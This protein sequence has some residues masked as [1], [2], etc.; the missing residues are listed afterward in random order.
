MPPVTQDNQS[1]G[2]VYWRSLD[3]LSQS[4]EFRKWADEEFGGY[5]PDEMVAAP[6]RRAFMK[7][8]GASMALAGAGMTGCRRWPEQKVAPYVERP[9]G[10]V[11]GLPE[12][13][14]TSY[15]FA[16]IAQPLLVSS[17]DGRPI[18]VE[19]N[20]QH[21][22]S[23]GPSTTY[24][25]ASVLDMYDP[26][27]SRNPRMGEDQKTWKEAEA[28][29]R[30]LVRVA[31]NGAGIAVL[32]E[33]TGSP[34][35]NSLRKRLGNGVKWYEYEAINADHERAGTK[36]AFGEA[37]RPQL[38]LDAAD[39]IVC[40]D[41]DPLG[42]HPDAL[43]NARGWAKGR[44]TVDGKD[45][46]ISRMYVVEPAYTV[47]GTVADDRVAVKAGEIVT[48]AQAI[49]AGAGV[50]GVTAGGKL[51]GAAQATVDAI[52]ADLKANAGK[53]VVIVG[54]NQPA[55]VHA[56]VALINAKSG[57]VG[58]TVSYTAVSSQPSGPDQ[59]RKLHGELMGGKVKALF[60]VGGNPVY[61]GPSDINLAEAIAD[62]G[63][64]AHL[65]V[66]DNETSQAC[67][68]H[69]ARS[70][71]LEAWGDAASYDGAIGVVQPLIQ[72]LFDT[73]SSV[74]LLGM[75]AGS[76]AD[77]YELVR[78]TWKPVLTGEGG[79]ER[80]WRKVLHDGLLEGS[81]AA[82]VS[83]TASAA[84]G[85]AVSAA[86]PQAA[87]D[88]EIVFTPS[89]TAYDGRLANNGWLQETPEPIS[90]LV[91]DNAA[92]ISP[93]TAKDNS[94]R[95]GD[96]LTIAVGDVSI[97][98][99][100][101]ILPG[102]ANGSIRL[103]LGYGRSA[104]G[105]VGNGVGFNAYTLRSSKTMGFAS[106]TVEKAGGKFQLVTTQDHHAIDIVG[107]EQRHKRVINQL[108]R[109]ATVDQYEKYPHFVEQNGVPVPTGSNG[110]TPLQIFEEPDYQMGHGEAGEHQWAMAIDLN[111]CIGCNACMVAC[112]AENNIPIVGKRE[113]GRGREMHWIRVDRYFVSKVD[114]EG[115]IDP[116]ET[117]AAV[118][119]PLTCQ[120]CENAPCEQV[121][122][123][124]ATV[125]DTEGLNVMIY[126]RCIGTRYCSNNCPY[127]VRRYNWFD[128][129][130][131]PVRS[132]DEGAMGDAGGTFIGIPDQQQ[133]QTGQIDPK[134]GRA[135]PEVGHVDPI[136][137]LGFNPEVTV[138]MRGVMEKCSFCVQ[139]IKAVTIPLRN[140]AVKAAAT[141]DDFEYELPDGAITPACG[142]T[143][144]TNAIKFGDLKDP[145]S[146]VAKIY[147]NHEGAKAHPRAYE[148]L[149]ELNPR[150]RNRY[151]GPV[152]NPAVGGFTR[153]YEAEQKAQKE[154]V[155]ENHG[156]DDHGHDDKNH[157]HDDKNKAAH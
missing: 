143:C 64:S 8:M 155:E 133:L 15:E 51:S 131:K 114:G 58:K 102:Q 65:S 40:L 113:C 135:N 157:D 63:F 152:R 119:Q 55:E 82:T 101:F 39:I 71:Y 129:N 150:A 17:Y 132:G 94:I 96:R 153:D 11:P 118:H 100:A 144:P 72:P 69:L 43:R 99:P 146:D 77:G 91:W 21:P 80:Q 66:Y 73:K 110:H 41:A 26:H 44:S 76:D 29:I 57:A 16:G 54:P 19:G 136:R 128:W 61:D 70:H 140:K 42:T 4:P 34:T 90:K 156:H 138:R 145:G 3:E 35:S 116:N 60:I 148:I 124:A 93:R 137:R 75:L 139:R 117:V 123:V 95:H 18:K 24:A 31:P 12:T 27:R 111:A 147:G 142:Q 48:V 20:P 112:Q 105:Y 2:M 125:H 50:D 78:Q 134:T 74:E 6:S 97:V 84:A 151:L 115:N 86:K 108:V 38:K 33:A 32:S 107:L 83:V 103:D 89:A 1:T 109:G 46:K 30:E 104:A 92:Y 85:S 10:R 62:I 154:W 53:A 121:C 37:V 59:L 45:H 126:N 122:P 22:A 5:N 88:F 52:V 68:W 141:G 14:A 127:K 130:F 120:Q 28:A 49:A 9:A 56:A 149:R 13:F 98:A 67:S 36:L 106:A 23:G 81:G 87:G 7:I 47:S 79:F 25:Q